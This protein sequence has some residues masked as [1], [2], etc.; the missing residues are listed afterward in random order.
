M[1]TAPDFLKIGPVCAVAMVTCVS[2][3]KADEDT[4]WSGFY[5]GFDI[6]AGRSSATMNSETPYLPPGASVAAGT[7][8]TSPRNAAEVSGLGDGV[9]DSADVFVGGAV[10][11][12]W[13]MGEDKVVGA[14]FGI[15]RFDL[16]EEQTKSGTYITASNF[17]SSL[18]PT[19]TVKPEADY[20]IDLTARYGRIVDDTLFYLKGGPALG[21]LGYSYSF[22][23]TNSSHS[24]SY[25]R[26]QLGWTLGV[27]VERYVA[28]NWIFRVE[29]QHLDFGD[30]GSSGSNIISRNGLSY[31]NTTIDV[32]MRLASDVV[33][34]GLFR[35]F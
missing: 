15:S 30:I 1:R 4:A 20:S 35:S 17:L 29:Y 3:S 5:A 12:N 6:G 23:D 27:G 22:D 18:I 7:F 33:R 25:D 34:V 14:E 13:R 24:H 11:Y 31:P 10:G 28:Q 32:D 19:V 9:I 8:W 16:N 2:I 26:F 21:R